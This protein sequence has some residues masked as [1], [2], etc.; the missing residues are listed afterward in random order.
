[1]ADLTT[2][3]VEQIRYEFRLPNVAVWERA[4][5]DELIRRLAAEQARVSGLEAKYQRANLLIGDMMGQRDDWK[6]RALAAGAL[7]QNGG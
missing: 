6:R 3:S 7:G 2:M 4:A 1:M 5:V